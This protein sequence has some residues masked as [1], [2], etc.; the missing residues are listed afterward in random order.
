M[1]EWRFIAERKIREGIEEGAFDHLEGAGKPLDLSENPFEDPSDRMA[2][3]L[4]KN[5]GFAPS[6]IEEAKEIEAESRRLRA[7]GEV[8]KS[9]FQS[10]VA[11]LNRKIV[12][13]NLKAPAISLHKR[14][15]E[16]GS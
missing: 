4:L 13:F 2:H 16:F 5:N 9:D 12:S 3:R 1:D 14:L 11:A 10:R 7:R 15:F 6:W 8:S